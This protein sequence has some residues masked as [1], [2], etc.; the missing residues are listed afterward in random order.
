MT[1]I[2]AK[3]LLSPVLWR[4][5]DRVTFRPCERESLSRPYHARRIR[6]QPFRSWGR[7]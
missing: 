2:T 6:R 1:A 7:V 5:T 4:M 3:L